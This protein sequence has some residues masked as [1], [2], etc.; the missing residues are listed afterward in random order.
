MYIRS[1]DDA[2]RP[3]GRAFVLA[4]HLSVLLTVPL[5]LAVLVFQGAKLET[6]LGADAAVFRIAC[7]AC[8]AAAFGRAIR[9][10]LP[11]V[12]PRRQHLK[13]L[14]RKFDRVA[15]TRTRPGH[16]AVF[17]AKDVEEFGVRS[18]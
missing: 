10:V 12:L 2:L 17:A 11:D 8:L 1:T 3:A 9:I 6:A 4:C 5:C 15:L 14:A 7:A 13:V 18:R 16:D